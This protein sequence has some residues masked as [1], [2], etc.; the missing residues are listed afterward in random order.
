MVQ[1]KE[2]YRGTLTEDK[3]FF[4]GCVATTMRND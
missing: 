2:A 1:T 3:P 4:T